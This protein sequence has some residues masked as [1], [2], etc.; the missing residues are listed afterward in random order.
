[1]NYVKTSNLNIKILLVT[2]DW[3]Q[4]SLNSDQRFRKNISEIV[5][6]VANRNS[7][8]RHL[9]VRTADYP[10]SMSLEDIYQYPSDPLSHL[11]DYS[12]LSDFIAKSL[13]KNTSS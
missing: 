11:H 2:H 10:A 13:L 8:T 3:A 1:V 4:H 7:F 6:S 12:R 9:H 5:R